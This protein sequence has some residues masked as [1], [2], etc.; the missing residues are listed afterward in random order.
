VFEN[1]KKHCP[2]CGMETDLEAVYVVPTEVP[3][4][5]CVTRDLSFFK[6]LR[7]G[8]TRCIVSPLFFP[9][10]FSSSGCMF[11]FVVLD[12]VFSI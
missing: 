7:C 4:V 12:L 10:S 11:A 6:S 1:N 8:I 5:P 9:S 2:H 3:P